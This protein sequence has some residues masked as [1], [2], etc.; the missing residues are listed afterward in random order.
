MEETYPVRWILSILI[1]FGLTGWIYGD[2]FL[3]TT[4]TL[5]V[6]AVGEGRAALLRVDHTLVLV[7]TGAGAEILRSLGSTLP[8]WRRRL[9]ALV[10]TSLQERFSGAEHL[11]KNRYTVGTTLAHTPRIAVGRVTLL[12]EGPF[13]FTLTE[14]ERPLFAV[15]SST[16]PG[17]YVLR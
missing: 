10:F 14:N 12:I 4:P 17:T 11:L 9:D 5:T 6:F 13:T 15:S 2:L 1:L 8:P 3:P 7:D 16:L